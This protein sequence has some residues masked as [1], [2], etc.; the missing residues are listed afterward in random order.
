MSSSGTNFPGP[1]SSYD[2]SDLEL[3]KFVAGGDE[4]PMLVLI[5]R[6]LAAM[7]ALARRMLGPEDAEDIAQEA[8]FRLWQKASGLEL[9]DRGLRPWLYRVTS[10]LCLDQLRK[11]REMTG[12][13]MPE[14]H[15]GPEQDRQISEFE[16]STRVKSAIN[17][18]PERQRLALALFHL[19]D[20]SQRETAEVMDVTEEALESLLRRARTGL[21]ARLVDEWKD[22]IPEPHD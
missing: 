17:E 22:L 15:I 2:L 6:H 5:E 20:L 18:L 7:H 9:D 13:E 4:K 3:L 11:R 16:M 14:G 10:N 1:G 8:M 21:K 12:L 19:H